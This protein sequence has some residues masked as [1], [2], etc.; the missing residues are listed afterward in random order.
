MKEQLNLEGIIGDVSNYQPVEL[1][2]PEAKEMIGT[3]KGK[4]TQSELKTGTSTSG[5]DWARVDLRLECLEDGLTGRLA[6]ITL[7]LGKEPSMFGDPDKSQTQIFLDTI[8]TAGLKFENKTAEG[9]SMSVGKL[10]GQECWFKSWHKKKKNALTNKYELQ[11][12]DSGYK[13]LAQKLVKP[14]GETTTVANDEAW[15]DV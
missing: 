13:V 1:V 6:F 11:F 5:K 4:I 15:D 3:F 10:V 2:E 8:D 12:N 7:F 9:F 14:V